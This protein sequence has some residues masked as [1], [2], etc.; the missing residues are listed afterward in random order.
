M[1]LDVRTEDEFKVSHLP[2]AV[3]EVPP[4]AI[5]SGRPVVAYC[6]IG[7]RSAEAV[8]RL[9]QAGHANVFNLEGS[10][11]AWAS[12]GRPLEL[13]GQAVHK[14]H[15]FD[16]KWGKLLPSAVRSGSTDI[17]DEAMARTRLRRWL[18]GP[19][20]LFLLLCGR[21]SRH[22]CRCFKTVGEHAPSTGYATSALRC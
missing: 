16:S 8:R 18:T 20:L 21:R 13:H 15:P 9:V 12:E 4:E 19:L 14:V 2:N 11:F 22:S 17:G 5:A 6:S 3:R 1:L 7:W 10:I